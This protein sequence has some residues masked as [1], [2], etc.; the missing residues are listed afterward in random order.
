MEAFSENSYGLNRNELNIF[1]K[2]GAGR[3]TFGI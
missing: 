2:R 1:T 3:D